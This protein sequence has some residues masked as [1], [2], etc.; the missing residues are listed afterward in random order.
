MKQV[1]RV[2]CAV[3]FSRPSGAAFR[4]ALA[5]AK[6]RNAELNVVFAVPRRVRFNRRSRQ[7]MALLADLRRA[8]AADGVHMTVSAQHGD[9]ARV[10]LLH[11]NSSNAPGVPHLI[12]IGTHGRKGMDRFR[13]GSVAERVLHLAPCPTLIVRAS[14]GGTDDP[15]T[16]PFQRIL[17]AV[18][19]LPASL[20]A[21]DQAIRIF[22]EGAGALRLLHV[23]GGT[24]PSAPRLAWQLP[25]ADV[26][27]EPSRAAWARLR[28][29]LGPSQDLHERAHI[30]VSAGRVEHEIARVAALMR[31][32]LVVLGVTA[33]GRL[34]RL[35]GS[36]TV[37]LLRAV[38]CPVLVVP[39]RT[40]AEVSNDEHEVITPVAA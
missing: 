37:R 15:Q 36:T 32:D 31:A 29:L 22:R 19:F 20:S 12:V 28:R 17:C 3:D 2:M 10:I 39:Q 25:A 38:E 11:A 7:R 24:A 8:A 4:H 6:S 30:Q 40:K 21:L 23:V 9:P 16:R 18:D 1:S 14:K 35:F 33:R 5:V 34:A 26:T 13:L 27:H